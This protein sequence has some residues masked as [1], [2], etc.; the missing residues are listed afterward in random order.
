[1]TPVLMRKAEG[2]LRHGHRGGNVKMRKAKG[3]VRCLQTKEC[4]ELPAT[5]EAKRESGR[6]SP[7]S[8]GKDK[9]WSPPTP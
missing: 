2:D 1:V 8:L 9:V 5:P 4:Q 3:G 7:R 6:G